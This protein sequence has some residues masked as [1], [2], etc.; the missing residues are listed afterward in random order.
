MYLWNVDSNEKPHRLP[1]QSE[2]RDNHDMHWS[3]DGKTIVFMSVR[4]AA[5]K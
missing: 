4:V 2:T 1:G 3:P 5:G